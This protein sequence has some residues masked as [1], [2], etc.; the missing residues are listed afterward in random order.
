[1]LWLIEEG[2]GD[3]FL[4]EVL[5]VVPVGFLEVFCEPVFEVVQELGGE[6][7]FA[8]FEVFG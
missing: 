5:G 1:M 3:A 6:G 4:L 8:G 2:E 7:D